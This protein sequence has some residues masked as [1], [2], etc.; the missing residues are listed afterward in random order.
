MLAIL[1]KKVTAGFLDHGIYNV[2]SNIIQQ[3]AEVML[4]LL[5]R[6]NSPYS[7]SESFAGRLA[8]SYGLYLLALTLVKWQCR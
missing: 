3:A 5:K 7:I 1:I 8:V 4:I 2:S 6:K